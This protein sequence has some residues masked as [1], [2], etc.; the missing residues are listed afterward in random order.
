[1][2]NLSLSQPCPCGGQIKR[3]GSA[4]QDCCGQWL[5]SAGSA[6]D[7]QSLMRSRYSAFVLERS[8]YLL[9]TWHVSSRPT[10]LEFDRGVKWLGLEVRDH[11]ALD[12]R[13]AAV[14]F[15]ARYKPAGAPAVRLHERS[16]FVLEAGRWYYLDGDSR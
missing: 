15:I 2:K 12:D 14:E 4:Y 16:R 6:P 7:A 3:V 10:L 1:M 8:D 13:H 9:R 11:M 5:E